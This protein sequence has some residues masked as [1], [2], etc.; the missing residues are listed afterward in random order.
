MTSE[1]SHKIHLQRA[2][3]VLRERVFAALTETDIAQQWWASDPWEFTGLVLDATPGGRF[4]YNIRNKEDGST[5]STHGEY[6]EVV[7]NE[8]LVW[9]NAEGGG[10]L[11]TVLFSDTDDGGTAID[12]TQGDFPDAEIRD[13][14]QGGWSQSL[15]Q[16]EEILSRQ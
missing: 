11:V 6:Q 5:Y 10:T 9:T 12:I 2:F 16:L 8:K 13:A 4:E 14:H 15:D 1:G 7:A 3:D